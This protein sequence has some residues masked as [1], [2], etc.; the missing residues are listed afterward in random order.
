MEKII[1]HKNNFDNKGTILVNT[2]DVVHPLSE[3]DIN[4]LN[5]FCEKVDKEY[6]SIGDAGESNNLLVGRF[7]TDIEKPLVVENPY[8]EKVIKILSQEKVIK[9]IKK[10]LNIDEEVF[11]RRVQF[12]QIDK[13]CFVGYHLDTD[14][15]PD[16]LAAGV[17]Q[18]GKNYKGGLYRVYQK[19][20][21]YFDYKSTFG[22]LIISNCNYPHEVTKVLDGER[23]SLVFFISNNSGKNNRKKK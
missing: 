16:Y 15:N 1:E 3:D 21:S 6:I 23:K 13:D 7:M 9:F 20:N 8:S 14:S 18:L 5:L 10:I 4:Q 17:I 19:N 2:S 12:N 22:D 11:L